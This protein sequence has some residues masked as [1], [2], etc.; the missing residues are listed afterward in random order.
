MKENVLFTLT[1]VCQSPHQLLHS[2]LW[3]LEISL[4]EMHKVSQKSL[5]T[6][7]SFV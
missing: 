5:Y 3:L 1:Q 6:L 4:H 2:I 7:I